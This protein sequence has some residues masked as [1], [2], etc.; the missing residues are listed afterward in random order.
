MIFCDIKSAIRSVFRSRI[1]SAISILG[2]G[3]GLGCIIVLT[4]L[5]F[6]ERSFDTF[7]PGYRNVYR[8]ILGNSAQVSFPLAEEMSREFPEVKDFFRYYQNGSFQMRNTRHEM[9]RDR[10]MGF[11]DTSIFRILGIKFITGRAAGS[12][13]EIAISEESAK[14]YFGDD[15][16]VGKILS[17]KFTDGFSDLTISGVYENFPANSTLDPLFIA[18]IRLSEKIF[19]QFQKSLGVYGYDRANSLDWNR[20]EFLSYVVLDRN[21]DPQKLSA[22]IG[23]YK[24]LI[25][26]DNKEEI[27]FRLQPV[28]DIYLGSS[29]IGGN[30]F[31]RQGNSEELKYYEAIAILILII[32]IA[33]YIL[34]TRAGIS[35][36]MH[37]LGTRKVFGASFGEIRRLIIIESTL[38]VLISLLPAAF[39]IDF[40]IDFINTTL[41]KTLTGRIFFTPGLW[42]FLVLLIILT[43]TVT[44][45]LIGLNY[46]RKPALMLITGNN[47][48]R[49]G[50]G[51]WNYSF[52]VLHFT[53]YMVL[54]TVVIAV[55]KQVRYS[56]SGYKGLNPENVVVASL[57]SDE[58][59]KSY[60]TICEEMKKVP[61][62]KNV[63]GGSFIPPFGNFLP[64]NLA[65]QGGEKVRFDG[66]IMGEGM[67]ELLGI[68]VIDGSSFGPYKEGLPEILINESAALKYNVKAGDKLLVF[69][70]MGVL[71]DFHAHSLHSPI[72]PMVILQQDPSKMGLIAIRTDGINDKGIIDRLRELFLTVAPDEVFETTFLTDR[73]EQFYQREKNQLKILTAFSLLAIMLAVMGLFG[74]SLFTIL[75][76]RKEIGIRKVNGSS[77][78]RVLLILNL[79]FMK[80]VLVAIV[81]SIPLSVWF[82]KDWM[83]RFAYRTSISWWIFAVA[84]VSAVIIAVLT[85]SWQSWRAATRNP[86]EALRY[87]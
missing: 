53:I 42:L 84:A 81:I 71:R 30:L 3:I 5:I 22:S 86:V 20:G 68:E 35:E 38:V 31:L 59:R 39:I 70:V 85:V 11:A 13:T 50:K 25:N 43:G 67:I 18:D 40:G 57:N 19:M 49:T 61:G 28:K 58:L 48:G 78:S 73:I 72:E 2:L 24:D 62:V 23:K 56:M 82:L 4:A 10:N 32:S 12:R 6:H 83:E 21:A 17:V 60:T 75:R 74:I 26:I 34:L 64:I 80:W 44:G 9:V 14:K 36:K 29:D 46:S 37:E 87:E 54:V 79:D 76:R 33:N 65:V 66:L 45:W 7:I 16:P 52:L 41:N 1:T 15:S 55:S 69:N 27:K 8:V 63:A 77:V 51:R 47:S